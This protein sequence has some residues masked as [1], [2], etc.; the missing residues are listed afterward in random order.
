MPVYNSEHFLDA[1]IKSI[2]NQTYSNFEFIIVDD[3]SKDKSQEIIQRY[4]KKE[5]RIKVYKTKHNSGCT[6][7]LNIGLTHVKGE[8]IARMDADDISKK[9]RFE[10]QVKFMQKNDLDVCGTNIEMIDRE[11]KIIEKR[12]Y[13]ND[14]NSII[15]HRSPLAHP[16][17]F[18]KRE[19]VIK[20]GLYDER[21][22]VSQDYD[23][24]LRFFANGAIFG[25][26]D[27]YLFKYRLHSNSTKELKTKKTIKTVLKI[28]KNAQ[29]NYG[30]KFSI[31][32][33]KTIALEKIALILPSK[34]VLKAYFAYLKLKNGSK[35]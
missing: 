33:K 5:K 2:L 17:A 1:A 21:F 29:K 28:K 16:T 32:A 20:Y 18:F 26:L 7:A 31:S 30:I 15:L 3:C 11:G 19:L 13:S 34:L 8:Y 27:E 4:E 14:I 6:H 35:E 23:L 22:K 12:I 25:I 10:K 24:W 9:T